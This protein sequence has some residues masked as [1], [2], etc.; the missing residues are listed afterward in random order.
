[1]TRTLRLLAALALLA[2]LLGPA[3]RAQDEPAARWDQTRVTAYAKELAQA[4][5]ELHDALD[6]MPDQVVPAHQRAFYQARDDVR[7]LERAA[8]GFAKE[9]EAGAS[10]AEVAP[11]FARIQSLR[12]SAE[13]NGRKALIPDAV[14]AKITPVGGALIKLAPYFRE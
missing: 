13:E 12:R 14:M 8:E 5:K 6:S 3:A 2:P 1:M 10:K 7:M 4:A 9:L 11:R